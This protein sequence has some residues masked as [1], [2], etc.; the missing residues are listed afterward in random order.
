[1]IQLINSVHF[2]F[3]WKNKCRYIRKA[4]TV[5]SVEEGG[6]NATD[7]NG[8]NGPLTL[9][10]LNSLIRHDDPFWFCI[11]VFHRV[12]GIDLLLRCD[13]DVHKLPEM[14]PFP[15]A[16]SPLLEIII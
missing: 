4:D 6:L 2:N 3:I 15:P 13:Y 9:K 7:F 10:W 11:P 1:M 8:M 5:K 14:I 12:G 16:S